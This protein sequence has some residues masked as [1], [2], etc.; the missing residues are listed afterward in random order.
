MYQYTC[1]CIQLVLVFFLLTGKV[2]GQPV[3]FNKVQPPSGKNFI[4]ITGMVQDKL[5]YMWLASKNGLFR[6]D[7]YQLVQYRNDP[8]DANSL[9]SD[10][11]ETICIDQ[12]GILWIGT[13]SNGLDRLDPGT[14]R[15]THYRN[16]PANPS[17]I[18]SNTILS[19]CVD[20]EGTLWVGTQGLERFN[21]EKNSFI[22]YKNYADDPSSLSYDEVRTIYED[23]KGELWIGTGSVYGPFGTN[24]LL[25]GLNRMDKKTGRFTRYMNDPADPHSLI[26][27]KVRAIFEDSKGNFWIGT[28]GD[29]LHRMDRA[30]GKFE[31]YPYDPLHPAKLSRPKLKKAPYYDH[32]T[33]ITEDVTGRLWIGSS[34]SGINY[35]N[36]EN[37]RVTHF[38]TGND[39]AGSFHDYSAW[40]TYT[41]REGVLWIST[42]HGSLYRINPLQGSIPFHPVAGSGVT[43][44]FQE[45]DLT[46]WIGT[47]H[48]GLVQSD[49]YDKILKS[50]SNDITD[51][52]SISANDI[53]CIAKDKE[54]RM[55]IG[56]FS[57]GINEFNTEKKIFTRYTSE[58]G[59]AASLPSNTVL[60]IY[61]GP[62]NKLWLGTFMGLSCFDLTTRKSRNFLFYPGDHRETGRNVVTSVLKDNNGQWWAGCWNKGGVQ[63][64]DPNT[65]KAV[66]YLQGASIICLLEDHAGVLWAAGNE[67]LY[68]YV[69]EKNIFQRFKEPA[70]LSDANN[71]MNLLEDEKGNIWITSEAGILLLNRRRNETTLFGKSYG[72]K[73]NELFALTGY[74][75]PDKKIYFGER[76]GYYGFAPD[77]LARGMKAPS[78]ILSEFRIAD[79]VIVPGQESLLQQPLNNTASIR[80]NYDQHVFS[81]SFAGIDY[82]NPEDNRHLFMLENYDADWNLAGTDRKAT[83]Y[84]VPPGKYIFRVKVVNSYGV[85]TSKSIEVIITPPWWKTWWFRITAVLFIITV[86]YSIIRWRLRQKFNR[87]LERSEKEKQLAELRQKTGELEMQALRAQMNPHFVFNSLNAINNFILQNNKIQASEYLT[88]FSRLVRMILQNSQSTLITLESELESL[89]LYLEL[90]ALRF[91]NRFAYIIQVNKDIDT[92]ILKVPPLIIQPYAENAIWHGLMHKEDKGTLLIDI[93]QEATHLLLTIKDDGVGRK[94]ASSRT[95]QATTK[96]K[97][98]GLKITADRIANLHRTD[99]ATPVVIHDLVHPNGSAAGTEVIIQIPVIYD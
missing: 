42:L 79:V 50:Y 9:G 31:R 44:I 87:Q 80:L 35:Y 98:L 94:H 71:L 12:K 1:C 66:A 43:A 2:A 74:I 13:F 59:N 7:G 33:F 91:D 69:K 60:T 10:D 47:A 63:Q 32:I 17:S 62:A 70:F 25:G 88:K 58:K 46:K 54:G 24:P 55:W 6:Y 89:R 64:F 11:L 75:G 18:C 39:T 65:G 21:P 78:I 84:N 23:R 53:S 86:F 48:E 52:R 92:D 19:L 95:A 30:T 93:R 82:S 83:Y 37:Q 85:W 97:S 15:F 81:F 28:A 49:R 26:N 73:G 27:N 61:P 96:H 67:G 51:A 20:K 38:E 72:I 3:F 14:G 68:K 22:H 34:E 57:N 8:L 36:P 99:A 45:A 77:E 90:E 16:D 40:W 5:G 29:G 56:T 76:T 4:H 41:S